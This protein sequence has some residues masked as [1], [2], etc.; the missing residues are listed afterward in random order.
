MT[1]A[2]GVEVDSSGVGILTL[3][4]PNRPLNVLDE[5]VL[6]ELANA[7]ADMSERPG[8]QAI[9]LR[10]GKTM[11]FCAG[12]DVNAI[13]AVHDAAE[14]TR[15][16]TLGQSV[17]A[18]IERTQRPVVAAV[19]G[20]CL[21]GGLEMVLG[22]HGVIAADTP[23]TELG[24]PE[25]L[26]GIV[27]GFGG[28][29]RLPRRVGVVTA[30]EMILTGKKLRAKQ[31]LRAGLV[32][33]VVC[34]FKL[35]LEAR[36]YALELAH[37]RPPRNAKARGGMKS[38]L[39]RFGPSRRFMLTQARKQTLRKTRGL[40]PAPALAIDLI[41]RAFDLDRTEAFRAE[42]QAIGTLLARPEAHR[43]VDLFLAM[44]EAKRS[45]E[46]AKGLRAGDRVVVIGSGVMGAGIGR[47]AIGRGAHVRMIDTQL[48]SLAAGAGRI[49][50]ALKDDERRKRRAA[51]ETD[52]AID[53]L[54]TSQTLSGL[55][56]ARC[57]IEAVVERLDVKQQLFTDLAA[58]CD[59]ETLFLTNTSSLRVGEIAATLPTKRSLV[60][61]HFFNPVDR[62]PLV[63]VVA[64]EG[65]EDTHVKQ[66]IAIAR[67]LGKT[68]I[69]TRDAPGFLVNRLLAPYLSEA[70]LLLEEGLAPDTIDDMM[71]DLGFAMGPLAVV[72]TV[73]LD[74][75]MAAAGS[76]EAFLGERLGRPRIG[77]IL[78][79]AGKLGN[80][81]QGGIRIRIGKEFRAASWL[82]EML[83]RARRE[84]GI[85]R[86][87]VA[88]NDARERMMCVLLNE[89][90]H[91]LDER[92][93][94]STRDL[95]CAMVLGAGFPPLRGGPISE[96]QSRG[97][98]Q[99]VSTLDDLKARF[100]V[101]FEAAP[102]LRRGVESGD[103]E[104][105]ARAP[106]TRE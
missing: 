72:D 67:D 97:L 48:A 24:L 34:P 2:V 74:V 39:S 81:T 31:A 80:K 28:T 17:A 35:D 91:A 37:G 47:Q 40:Y 5:G 77:R 99:L 69:V 45:A 19:H 23:Q 82:D 66:A 38:F 53:R 89:A 59:S 49:V 83:D 104:L 44:E 50:S 42:A 55:E 52:R 27:P 90:V 18:R 100:G 79:E 33:D 71:L 29:Q 41:G 78:V 25:V 101:R 61:L 7:V 51:R 1:S 84:R 86:Q 58:R 95:D 32:D 62:M 12:A 9:V 30:L 96:I 94:R 11:G 57:V 21:G 92:V 68:P 10:S 15:L 70:L 65:A 64:P 103:P 85:V 6:L 93:V 56:G 76:L 13:S 16:S 43:L 106:A 36:N 60:G 4:V 63:E 102:R 87:S 88:A 73:G 26:L 8:V 54:S 20:A 46:D 75:A 98:R 3:D 14:A 105:T 22:C